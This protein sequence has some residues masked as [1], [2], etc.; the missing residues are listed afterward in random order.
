MCRRRAVFSFYKKQVQKLSIFLY[1]KRNRNNMLQ[2]CKVFN[3]I[4]PYFNLPAEGSKYGRFLILDADITESVSLK[5][6]FEF[7]SAKTKVS[8]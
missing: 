7:S 2:K 4:K 5:A 8:F 6:L 3:V 1:I